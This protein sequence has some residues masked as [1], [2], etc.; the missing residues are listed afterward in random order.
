M[1]TQNYSED[2]IKQINE[3]IQSKMRLIDDSI[4]WVESNL[5]Y[6]EKNKVL[7]K[8]KSA[9]N[10]L[11]KIDAR[12]GNKPVMAVFGASQ[13]GK[14]YLIKN[15][16][17]IKG[18]PFLIR[19]SSREYD[20]LKEINPAGAG[21]ESTGIVTR[22][23]IN[24]NSKFE[25]FP[26]K[27][28]LLSVKDIL[29]IILDSFFL[30]LNRISTFINKRDLEVHIKKLEL[31][32]D[33]QTQKALNEYDVLEIKD[34]FENHLIK[35]SILFEG[36]SET[37]FFER[38]GKIIGYF[39]LKR[40]DNIF[41][42][43]WNKDE[44]LSSL[45]TNLIQRLD[46]LG[47]AKYG[48][49]SFYNVLRDG[50]EILDVQRL[51]DLDSDSDE[52]IFKS[53]TGEEFSISVSY[54]SALISELIF[55]IPPDLVHTKPFL[56]NSDLL[57]F[58]GARSRGGVEASGIKKN[59][60]EMLLRGK[61]S[62]LFNKYSDEYSIN[63][64]LFCA[65]D[66]Q[67]EVKDLSYLL[68][69]WIS[70]NIGKNIDDRS[71]SLG[72]S[73]IPP[74]FL[75]LTFF[76][77]QLKF[78]ETNDDGYLNY[79]S[80]LDD[81]WDKRFSRFFEDEIVTKSRN[82]H[83]QW[84]YSSKDFKNFYLLRDF[85]Y[86][87]A[88]FIRDMTTMEE[89]AYVDKEPNSIQFLKALKQSFINYP[90]VKKHFDNP[91]ESWNAASVVN[92]DGSELIIK[93]LEEVS[94]NYSKINHYISL[95][96]SEVEEL[97]Q[98]LNKYIRTDNVTQQ[99][100]NSM[101]A[102]AGLELQF[103]RALADDIETFNHLIDKLSLKPEDVYN[104]LIDNK[105]IDTSKVEQEN[106]S[107]LSIL[108]K[109]YPEISEAQHLEEVLQILKEKMMLPT[110]E[111]V[112]KYLKEEGFNLENAFNFHET[113]SKSEFY[114]NLVI[115]QWLENISDMDNFE[116]L[117]NKSINR[118]N[119]E[120]VIKHFEKI[121]EKREVKR[122]LVKILDDVV[123]QINPGQTD[124]IFLAETFGLI[125]NDIVYNFDINYLSDE[126][127]SE[128]KSVLNNRSNSFFDIRPITGS[129]EISA[130]FDNLN[131]DVPSIALEKYKRWIEFLRISL[132]VNS[133]F[134]DYDT[135]ENEKLITL[136]DNYQ[137]ISL[138]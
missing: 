90:F 106:L 117:T 88:T 51:K 73:S 72:N 60:Y 52:T 57:D 130:L 122:K 70:K 2:D 46:N 118:N 14:S 107:Q 81:K 91:E 135:N 89:I 61:V 133:G 35:H 119:I 25:D 24:D 63:N 53:E 40:W 112:E 29:I 97:N 124:E 111:E 105:F 31:E 6:E 10:K 137:K 32:K 138:N 13:V 93:N 82:W 80:K 66:K 127:T 19:D 104:L 62:Y 136:V 27:I 3:F 95:L 59:I 56:K 103:T 87:E 5:K 113:E 30:D 4:H 67:V 121:F 77:N 116:F 38:I 12:V 128:I 28:E 96:N 75:I 48:Y 131:L 120:F 1:G 64:L 108:I 15:L 86:S 39:D 17:S 83:I 109:S 43:L 74:L 134:V 42:I 41:N 85:K 50:G 16:L 78:D 9:Q 129:N 114:T 18:K 33:N 34:Y 7:L 123:S 55:S 84:S 8:L 79:N 102:V 20:F 101:R 94:N 65:N 125:I 49:I 22:F 98:T 58:P 69:N 115:K 92:Q 23:T 37:R 36:L 71:K 44:S 132:I 68:F 11:S 26:I 21:A 54:L 126:E 99:R 100:T 45:F 76:N 47:Y 110:K